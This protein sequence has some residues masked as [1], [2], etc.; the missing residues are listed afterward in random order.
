MIQITHQQIL[1]S[2]LAQLCSNN[3]INSTFTNNF[4][5]ANKTL[6]LP[7]VQSAV[8]GSSLNRTLDLSSLSQNLPTGYS[9]D[10]NIQTPAANESAAPPLLEA[11]EYNA[12]EINNSHLMIGNSN[13]SYIS[14]SLGTVP[15]AG[16]MFQA[17]VANMGN[18]AWRELVADA[19]SRNGGLGTSELG[20]LAFSKDNGFVRYSNS[21]FSPE[22]NR[23]LAAISLQLGF[24]IEDLPSRC[25]DG[26][27]TQKL[28]DWVESFLS[29][30]EEAFVA[31][32][33]N[34][35]QGYQVKD[36][37][38]LYQAGIDPQ[39]GL[40]LSM[41]QKL[42][43][44]IR[45]WVQKHLN[46]L[47]PALDTISK[48]TAFIPGWGQVVSGVST[49]MNAVSNMIATGKVNFGYVVD[50]LASALIGRQKT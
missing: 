17:G 2:L 30:H 15:E 12:T 29:K 47:S 14:A 5:S 45:G 27:P 43:G 31:F 16:Q 7:R 48:V 4:N 28:N 44:G 6:F 11:F 23:R 34:P 41:H 24:A 39:S 18:P 1:N 42:H 49:G 20:Y 22:Q 8:L 33:N 9:N 40:M 35:A 38:R 36:G 10:L 3:G 26:A 25:T 32:L 46:W 21:T 13:K 19:V 37:R 50:Y